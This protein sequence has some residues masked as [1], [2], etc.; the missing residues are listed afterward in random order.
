[1]NVSVTFRVTEL[2]TEP[3]NRPP[4]SLAVIETPAGPVLEL[5]SAEKS[6]VAVV[7]DSVSVSVPVPA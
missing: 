1:M 6:R 3:V 5:E 2:D 7:P 4:T